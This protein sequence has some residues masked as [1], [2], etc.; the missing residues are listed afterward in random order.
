MVRTITL[1][2]IPPAGSDEQVVIADRR[3]AIR[4]LLAEPL[5]A[6]GRVDEQDLA[7]IRRQQAFLRDWFAERFGWRFLF[8][9]RQGVGRLYKQ[10]A[11]GGADATRGATVPGTD[12]RPMKRRAYV[13]FCLA[14]AELSRGTSPQVV[15]SDLASDIRERG[16]TDGLEPYAATRHTERQALVDALRL[17]ADL[18]VLVLNDGDPG[19]YIDDPEANGLYTVDRDRLRMLIATDRAPSRAA[20]IDELLAEPEADTPDGRAR[21]ARHRLM[22]RI[23]ED[24]IVYEAELDPDELTYLRRARP[25]VESALELAGM[26]L[27]RRRE[28]ATAIDPTGYLSDTGF[29]STGTIGHA[30]LLV[31]EVLAASG[32]LSIAA[33]AGY[34]RKLIVTAARGAASP[35]RGWAQEWTVGD[36][37]PGRLAD[38]V[39]DHLGAFRL[40]RRE[41]ELVVPLPAIARHA[42]TEIIDPADQLIFDLPG[43]TP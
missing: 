10:V 31:A 12:R 26:S 4:A 13:L 9:S 14:C 42:T 18:G 11:P 37:A 20:G 19:A 25:A 29:P 7:S 24:P 3:R 8:E 38:V 21:Q 30:S 39:V 17:L 36:A 5:A 41:G 27:E 22:R 15:V 16:A 23:F 6:P 2:P 33:V 28:G 43:G 32:P 34:L 35:A 40:A 1:R